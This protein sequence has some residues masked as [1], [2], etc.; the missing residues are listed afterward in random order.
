M[1]PPALRMVAIAR[2]RAAMPLAVQIASIPEEIR[3]FGH[4]KERHLKAAKEKE[5]R[6]VA[7][8]GVPVERRVAA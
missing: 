7:A 6:L 2:C 5:A 4:V 1:W 8:F 3:G